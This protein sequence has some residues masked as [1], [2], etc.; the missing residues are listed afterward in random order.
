MLTQYSLVCQMPGAELFMICAYSGTDLSQ[1][2]GITMADNMPEGHYGWILECGQ[3]HVQVCGQGQPAY[4]D[5]RP[6]G[7]K[8]RASKVSEG[9]PMDQRPDSL[10]G[11]L[12]NTSLDQ[13]KYERLAL[14]PPLLIEAG[15]YCDLIRE[16]RDVFVDGHYYACVAMCGISFE[17]FQRDKAKPYGAKQ[18]Q[19]IGC[20]RSMLEKK[21]VLKPE[22]IKLCE[23]MASLR[24]KYVHGHGLKPLE[25]ALKSLEWMRSFIDNE[26]NLMRDYEVV[27][28]ML[29]RKRSL[30]T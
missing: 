25:D 16:A 18:S 26:T 24:N 11:F 21:K 30:N 22:S 15:P 4:V 3:G 17:R 20:V 2:L 8:F 10:P 1:V 7:A 28:G 9:Q 23:K 27:N 6:N 5:F 13:H 12:E 14:L 29:N 19:K